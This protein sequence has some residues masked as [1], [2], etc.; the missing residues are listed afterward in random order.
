MP[1][2]IRKQIR[3]AAVVALTNLTTTSTRVF[4]N[5]VYDLQDTDLP[6]LRIYTNNEDVEISSYGYSRLL[7]RS[8]ELVVECCA[9]STTFDDTVD[10]MIQEVEVAIAANQGMGGA[11]YVQLKRIEIEMAGEG[12]KP[13]GVARMTFEVPYIT[14]LATPDAAL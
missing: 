10:L 1:S 4:E 5:R 12:E 2:H 6:G 3:D 9:K 8:L 14:A 7:D 13:I 11:K